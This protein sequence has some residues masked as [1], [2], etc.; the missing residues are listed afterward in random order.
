[1]IDGPLNQCYAKRGCHGDGPALL[2]EQRGGVLGV[3]SEGIL[4]P[5]CWGAGEVGGCDHY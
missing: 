4:G 1:M 2:R 5:G 3:S